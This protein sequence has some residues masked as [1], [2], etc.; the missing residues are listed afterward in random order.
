MQNEKTEVELPV[1]TGVPSMERAMLMMA[2][3]FQVLKNKDNTGCNLTLTKQR[4]RRRPLML[5][6]GEEHDTP[7]SA[8]A[9]SPRASPPA[10]SRPATSP[11][12]TSPPAK[13]P[14]ASPAATA[15]TAGMQLPT[16]DIE[17]D[18]AE[19][20][21]AAYRAAKMK[22]PAAAAKL[23]GAAGARK[24]SK[25][26]DGVTPAAEATGHS[27]A[28]RPASEVS[29]AA[30]EASDSSRCLSAIACSSKAR[31]RTKQRAAKRNNNTY[32]EKNI[33]IYNKYI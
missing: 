24:K 15:Q 4:G 19:A 5:Q 28:S 6:D 18:A 1:T 32:F 31:A 16:I 27:M 9:A 33:Y 10:A 21:A 30:H 23:P 25:L 7:A 26:P 29:S 22:R 2:E 3:M 14:A 12:T 20:D 13:S 8:P 11:P 17:E